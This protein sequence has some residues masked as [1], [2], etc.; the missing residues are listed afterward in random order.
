MLTVTFNFT[1]ALVRKVCNFSDKIMRQADGATDHNGKPQIRA[2]GPKA[3]GLRLAYAMP[4]F[5]SR[6]DGWCG[7]HPSGD[8]N[9]LPCRA[10]SSPARHGRAVPGWREGRRPGP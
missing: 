4:G 2:R 5:R 1:H 7:K 8:R 6:V 9:R 3:P 10:A